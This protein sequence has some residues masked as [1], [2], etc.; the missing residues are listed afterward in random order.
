[1]SRRIL[2]VL[3]SGRR[4]GNTARLAE[5][6]AAG[7]TWLRGGSKPGATPSV[8]LRVPPPSKREAMLT[9]P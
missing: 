2:I 5:A 7:C 6:F 8:T 4:R 1:M 3:C 9:R